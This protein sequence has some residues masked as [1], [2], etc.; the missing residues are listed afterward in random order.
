DLLH[1]LRKPQRGPIDQQ[2][3][4]GAKKSASPCPSPA[5]RTAIVSR[6]AKVD[7]WL[8]HGQRDG[9]FKMSA[10]RQSSLALVVLPEAVPE[11]VPENFCRCASMG[12]A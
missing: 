4:K 7:R 10:P 2:G 5:R 1:G 9:K 6:R 3:N 8:V 11:L 12:S